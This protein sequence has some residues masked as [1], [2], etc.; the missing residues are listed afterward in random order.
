MSLSA[1]SAVLRGTG[2]TYK[3]YSG[4]EYL[5]VARIG[6]NA[7][8]SSWPPSSSRGTGGIGK[9]LVFQPTALFLIYFLTLGGRE[10]PYVNFILT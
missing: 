1:Q 7:R 5:T 3:M 2:V 4:W 10:Y 9:A 8:A 6:P